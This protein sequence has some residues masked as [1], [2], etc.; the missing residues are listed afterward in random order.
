MTP[1]EGVLTKKLA[2][3]IELGA[4]LTRWV[5]ATGNE[6]P[7]EEPVLQALIQRIESTNKLFDEQWHRYWDL[8]EKRR[9]FVH[10]PEGGIK[11]INE[12]LWVDI[13][14]QFKGGTVAND[15]LKVLYQ[16]IH[17]L[18]LPCFPVTRRK[19]VLYKDL[20][21]HED[22]YALLGQ[23]FSWLLDLLQ[24]VNFSPLISPCCLEDYRVQARQFNALTQEATQAA[25]ILRNSQLTQHHLYRQLNQVMSAAR[26]RM[27]TYKRK[28]NG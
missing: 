4:N 19:P 28:K 11:S 12:R 25:E 8:S 21:L 18:S 27:L 6:F 13:G 23:Y 20:R 3:A 10:E 1:Y 26:G 9:R 22:S 17:R 7:P 15:L 24:I 2:Q 5:N 14:Y 16:K